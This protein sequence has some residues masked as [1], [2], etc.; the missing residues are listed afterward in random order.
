MIDIIYRYDPSRPA[1]RKEP[2]T[3]NEACHR[4]ARGNEMFANLLTKG[5]NQQIIYFNLEDVG[6]PT[7]G[8]VLPQEPYAIVLGCS[9]ARVPTEL[10][11][12]CTC[13]EMFV[14]RVAGNIL[15]AEQLGSID[16]AVNHIG[17]HLRVMV[18]LGHSRCGAVTAAVD[19]FLKPAEY[20][21]LLASHHV[22]T[23]VNSLFP[24]VRGAAE[25][26][27]AAW[28]NDVAELSGYRD[29]LIECAVF[30]N[31]ALTGSILLEEFGKVKKDMRVVFGVYDMASRR[32]HVPVRR[33]RGKDKGK[34]AEHCLIDAPDTRDEF[35]RL[36]ADV[37]GGPW[38]AKLLGKELEFRL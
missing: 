3:A 4:L 34:I 10:I 33:T 24:A 29:A 22:R 19:A 1:E 11:F 16:Y 9:D 17:S 27:A 14:V 28:G 21:A 2:T 35:G 5:D 7:S 26:L 37:A 30:L 15:G 20:L 6:L 8:D 25:S 18:V 31:A 38:I 32:V 13:N 23:I 36:A 12:D